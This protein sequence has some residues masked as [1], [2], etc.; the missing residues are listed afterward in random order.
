ML[1]VLGECQK[2]LDSCPWDKTLGENEIKAA[3]GYRRMHSM[4]T[5]FLQQ[6]AKLAWIQNGSENSGV[7]HQVII[8]RRFLNN[9]YNIH[10]MNGSWVETIQDVPA[11]FLEYYKILLGSSRTTRYQIQMKVFEA[12]EV[13]NDMQ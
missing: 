13:L 11:A 1:K 6:K 8:A 7:F 10:D 9:V 3:A 12:G 2:Q 5:N 4:C